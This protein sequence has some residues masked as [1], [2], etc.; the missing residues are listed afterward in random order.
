MDI[1]TMKGEDI[2]KLVSQEYQTLMRV[3]NNIMA[4]NQELDRR[5]KEAE[6]VKEPKKVK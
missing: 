4:L 6:P 5:E 3:Q 2:A 1:K